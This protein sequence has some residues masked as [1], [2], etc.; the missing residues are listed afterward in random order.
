MGSSRFR[1]LCVTI[2]ALAVAGSWITV[3]RAVADGG[4][5]DGASCPAGEYFNA[6]EMKYASS[7]ITNNPDAK[8]TLQGEDPASFGVPAV[9]APPAKSKS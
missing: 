4:H 1:G 6:T 9:K 3:P 5:Y 2:T 7:A 8:V